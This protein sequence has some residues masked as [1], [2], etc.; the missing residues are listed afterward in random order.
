MPA[1]LRT[2]GQEPRR[3]GS[4]GNQDNELGV[5]WTLRAEGA[6][7]LPGPPAAMAVGQS[8][9]HGLTPTMVAY[10]NSAAC[11]GAFSRQEFTRFVLLSSAVYPSFRSVLA[12]VNSGQSE[13]YPRIRTGQSLS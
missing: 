13:V 6:R 12:A 10:G 3:D 8:R 7:E 4:R 2:P 1:G 9:S 11:R 5:F